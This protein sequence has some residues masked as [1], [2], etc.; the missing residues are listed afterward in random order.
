MNFESGPCKVEVE[1]GKQGGNC[2]TFGTPVDYYDD[3]TLMSERESKSSIFRGLQMGSEGGHGEYVTEWVFA[4]SSIFHG[5]E[6]GLE[7]VMLHSVT[8]VASICKIV[9][10]PGARAWFGACRVTFRY[11]RCEHL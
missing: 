10:N 6:H 8:C 1:C 2:L 9:K 3:V 11:I 7:H 4:A 5:L